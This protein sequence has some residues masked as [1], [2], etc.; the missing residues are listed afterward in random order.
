MGL[1]K[2]EYNISLY[3]IIFYFITAVMVDFQKKKNAITKFTN[4]Q[5]EHVMRQ[6]VHNSI[7]YHMSLPLARKPFKQIDTKNIKIKCTKFDFKK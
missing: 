6:I 1:E 7:R 4:L 2:G 3:R 5:S